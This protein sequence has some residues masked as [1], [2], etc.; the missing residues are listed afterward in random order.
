M[1]G[2]VGL[3]AA[4][5]LCALVG[6]DLGKGTQAPPPARPF[7]GIKLTVAAVG[8]PAIL[9]TVAPQCGDWQREH[10]AEVAIHQG[11]VELGQA[12][13]VADVLLIPADRLGA[14]VDVG[15]L[16]VLPQ[17]AVRPTAPKADEAGEE[18]GPPADR[19]A[20]DD[21]LPAFRDQV[22]RYG[23][24]RMAL[25]YGG[26]ALVLVYRRDAMAGEAN[27]KAA[28]GAGLR[29]EPPATWEQLDALAGFFQGRDW[30]S[31]GSPD[32]GIAVA[33]GKDTEGLGEDTLLARAAGAG[34]HPDQFSFLFDADTMQPRIA[35]PPFV[36]ALAALAAWKTLGPPG[37]EGF[38]A[39][40]ARRA[41]REGKVALLIDRAERAGNWADPKARVAVGVA[42][43]PGS[44]R[45]YDPDRRAWEE[46]PAPNRPSYLPGGGGW[47]I[48]IS[49]RVQGLKG[50]AAL[51]LIKYLTGPEASARI[52]ADRAFPTLP[53]R[54]D[55][56]V[57]PDQ[58]AI[59]GVVSL[60]WSKAVAETLTAPRV[61][62][63]LR[64][65]G[66][67]GY[68]ADLE[69]GR[70]AAVGGE[71]AESALRGVAAAWAERTKRL[72]TARQLWH[73]RR[74]LNTFETPADP[75]AR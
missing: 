41:F 13:E 61:V 20:F 53:V 63:G 59:P 71:P 29:L 56:L 34:L 24:D 37:A 40:A 26:S 8:D 48:G 67:D 66:A 33:L 49:S 62:P 23:K 43:L 31:D 58:R 9:K 2:S 72:G 57:A 74:S 51:E 14:L 45:L 46:P 15:A 4:V 30:D 54:A 70:V 52:R 7:A 42:R 5:G 18:R 25:P 3:L 68:L 65:P 17:S 69:V 35:S 39:E 64:I 16:A 21:V 50:K 19:F 60:Q 10:D 11:A 1:R 47:L 36:E 44:R 22:T 38:D 32:S 73:Y 12:A 6:C 28:D 75:P 55:Q 27:R